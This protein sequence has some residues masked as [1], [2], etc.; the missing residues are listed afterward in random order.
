MKK[1]GENVGAHK[2]MP[3][4]MDQECFCTKGDGYL[5]AWHAQPPRLEYGYKYAGGLG[6]Y[7]SS[8]LPMAIHAPEARKTFFCWG[9]MARG[10]SGRPRNWDFCTGQQLHMVS[11][12]DHRTGL[13]PRPTILFDKYCADTH[14]NPVM[15]ID[16]DGHIWIFSPSHGEW[17]TPSFIHRSVEPYSIERFETVAEGL[18][19]YPQPWW[20]R[21]HGFVFL[22]TRYQN[23]RMLHLQVSPDGRQWSEPRPLAGIQQG[24][25]HVSAM[26]GDKIGMVFN[27]HPEI[28][29]LDARTNLY[30]MQSGDGGA[31]WQSVEGENLA[32][33]LMEV[34]N[35]ALAHDYQ[36]EKKLV[37][38]MDFNYDA[39]GNPVVLYILSASHIPGPDSGG[40]EWCVSRFESGRWRTSSVTVSDSNYDCGALLL[41]KNTWRII[42]P[43]EPGPQP[44][45][46]GGEM[47]RFVS[48]DRGENWTKE[49]V[50]TSQ[51]GCNH[52][53]A[54]RVL[55]GH[56][57]FAVLWAD[58]DTWK[59]NQSFLYFCGLDSDQV[60]RLPPLM[61]EDF[62]APE[63]LQ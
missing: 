58:G 59:F 24:H 17:T 51:S 25:Y 21:K 57:D 54:R 28:G 37:Y 10:E 45:T 39:D 35:Q 26:H 6:V 53:Y 11:Y 27:F 8:H 42:G 33:P 48:H 49:A 5:G 62:A 22:H 55:N 16:S 3:R 4:P 63:E 40:R 23:G 19:A 43:S 38:V 41:G 31:T 61:T 30:Y 13:V 47:A 12:Y 20:N 29:G 15:S 32:L 52:T 56:R 60:Y 34:H 1:F 7:C 18:F 36:K 44:W 14:D 46:P 2:I 9:G 50:L